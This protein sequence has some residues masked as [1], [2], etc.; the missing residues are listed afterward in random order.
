MVENLV[1]LAQILG[2]PYHRGAEGAEIAV[3]LIFE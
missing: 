2:K 1:L 3:D